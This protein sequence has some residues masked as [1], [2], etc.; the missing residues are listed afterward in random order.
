MSSELETIAKRFDDLV[1]ELEKAIRHCQIAVDHFR[2]KEVPRGCAHTYAMYGHLKIAQEW[3][4][5][6][7]KSFRLKANTD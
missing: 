2:S 4:D 7:A 1:P 3:F 5:E 6:F